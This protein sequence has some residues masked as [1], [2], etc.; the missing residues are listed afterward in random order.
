MYAKVN[1]AYTKDRKSSSK[2]EPIDD[3]I[4][5]WEEGQ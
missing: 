5:G 2:N 4:F 1:T 3:S